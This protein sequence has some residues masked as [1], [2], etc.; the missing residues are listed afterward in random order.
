MEFS[1]SDLLND[2]P[3]ARE[4]N[5]GDDFHILWGVALCLRMIQP[6]SS[7]R[8]IVIEGVAPRDR[9]NA[10]RR[11]F[12]AAD[13]TEYYGGNSF[14]EAH[15]VV[16]SQLKYSYRNPNQRWT[17]GRLAP[18]GEPPQK[19]VFGKLARAYLAFANQYGRDD[20]LD[21]LTIR[22]SS[23]QPGNPKLLRLVNACRGLLNS[24]PAS[25]MDQTVLDALDNSLRDDYRLLFERSGLSQTEF[26]DFLRVLDLRYLGAS[27]RWRQECRIA[28]TLAEHVLGDLPGAMRRLYELV[29]R[30]ALPEASDSQGISRA[31]V[32]ASLGV[33]DWSDLLPFASRIEKP[34][35]LVPQP[36]AERLAKTIVEEQAQ[37]V[38]AHGDA[39]VGKTT[40]L[41][42]LEDALPGD[43]IVVLYD[44]FA[45]GE[46]LS[47][48]ESRHLPKYAARQLINE[49]AIRC[50]TPLL[51]TTAADEFEVWQR[52]QRVLHTA[53][54]SVRATGGHVIIAID[55]A[56]NAVIASHER[57]DEPC[58]VADLWRLSLPDNVHLIMTCRTARRNLLDAPD[59]VRDLELSGFDQDASAV[60]FRHHFPEA[61]TTA[62]RAFHMNSS[63][64]PRIQSY[65]LD[66]KRPS[67]PEDVDGCINQAARTPAELF[68]DL[69]D[70]AIYSRPSADDSQKWIAVLMAL[71][72]PIR[73]ESL[74]LVLEASTDDVNEFCRALVPGV[75]IEQNTLAFRDEDFEAHVRSKCPARAII[76]AR[77]LI[78][79]CYM[80]LKDRHDWAAKALAGHLFN[81]KRL[82]QLIA[83]TIEDGEP[84]VIL[85]P[86]AR[87]QIYL[88]RVGLA[89]RAMP[90]T[91]STDSLKLLARAAATKHSDAVLTTLI[92]EKPELAMQYADPLAVARV[93][94]ARK[95]EAWKGPL[96][97]RVAA[98]SARRGELQLAHEQY[99]LASAWLRRRSELDDQDQARWNLEPDNIAALAEAAYYLQGPDAAAAVGRGCSPRRFALNVADLTVERLARGPQRMHIARHLEEQ[100]LPV[101]VEA[102]LIAV[103]FRSG[104]SVSSS[105]VEQVCRGV[106][107]ESP[108]ELCRAQ[109]KLACRSHRMRLLYTLQP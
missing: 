104:V 65:V 108:V 21:K 63:G 92:L 49:I 62:C 36:D 44:C 103:L 67:R 56:D 43:S 39:G 97:M 82:N 61:T 52:L 26:N 83:L 40:T 98:N 102:R 100:E 24:M 72:R 86:L 38:V 47:P 3:G 84:S 8:R 42:Q 107:G 31:D 95:D 23:N 89:L 18:K 57:Q 60:H 53:G 85:D 29:Q 99:M 51:L 45:G 73:L 17:P 90:E 30:Q 5:A 34:Q 88:H 13:I 11:A 58:F 27:D 2:L 46:Y 64:N 10:S 70:T 77:G 106:V 66:P 71:E 69:L 78:A 35:I 32:L 1:S 91:G 55:A 109:R 50:G 41:T 20:V 9:A 96:H 16:L 54:S 101:E 79:D 80:I 19:T 14:E 12:L 6:D 25:T 4:S 15:K 93:Y 33:T 75:R 94:E 22:L 68:D 37:R 59:A 105:H 81:S 48:A 7:L 76:E 87:K 28:T 74:S